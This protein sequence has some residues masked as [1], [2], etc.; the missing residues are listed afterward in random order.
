MI[1]QCSGS[2][3]SAVQR[4]GRGVASLTVGVVAMR[5]CCQNPHTLCTR[6]TSLNNTPTESATPVSRRNRHRHRHRYRRHVAAVAPPVR[7]IGPAPLPHHR[8]ASI[9]TADLQIRNHPFTAHLS[10]TSDRDQSTHCDCGCSHSGFVCVCAC[11][12]GADQP[13]GVRGASVCCRSLHG[14]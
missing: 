9:G 8:R 12:R 1:A 11:G 4:E 7:P 5:F 2:A 13:G 14:G 3:C 6:N 10:A